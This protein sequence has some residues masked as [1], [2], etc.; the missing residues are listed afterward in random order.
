MTVLLST[1]RLYLLLGLGSALTAAWTGWTGVVTAVAVLLV[2]A[3]RA[4]ARRAV[5]GWSG[6]VGGGVLAAAQHADR[7]HP[8]GCVGQ[9]TAHP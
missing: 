9:A 2:L 7:L 8:A 6:S 4:G 1:D 3:A 5:T